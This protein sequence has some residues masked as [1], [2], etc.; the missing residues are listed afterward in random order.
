[1]NNWNSI[2]V[3]ILR[4]AEEAVSNI[5]IEAGSAGVEINDSADYLNHQDLFGEVLPEV[6]QSEMVEVTAYYP[7]NLPIT[8]LKSDI[9]QKIKALAGSF[10]LSNV[11]VRTNNLAEQDWADAWKKYFEPARITHDLTIVPSWT[12]YEPQSMAEKLIRLD[13]GMAFGT[14]THPT[15]KMSLYALEQ[16]IRGGETVFDV[17]TG[18]GVLSVASAYLG[19]NEIYAYDIDE[20]AVRVAR[21]NIELNP[22]TEKIFVSA[23]NLLEGIEKKSRNNRR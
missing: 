3:S 1:M 13:P 7:E 15:T 22:N 16:V 12:D 19:A 4:A 14:G 17:G 21:E 10:D 18:S 11:E 9:E 23:N 6:E 20:V 2:T 5:L 8:E